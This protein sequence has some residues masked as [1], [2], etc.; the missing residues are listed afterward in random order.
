MGRTGPKRPSHL[1]TAVAGGVAGV[2]ITL[3]IVL[4]GKWT[5]PTG[6][7]S[8][9]N[10]TPNFTQ[11]YASDGAAEPRDVAWASVDRT[12][13]GLDRT[14]DTQVKRDPPPE[15]DLHLKSIIPVNDRVAPARTQPKGER[16]F[17]V[18]D[19]GGHSAT[20]RA[21][22]FLP[23]GEQALTVSLDKTVRIWDWQ[24][25]ETLR[26]L[27]LPVGPGAEGALW[28]GAVSPDGKLLAVGGT[29]YGMG[30]FGVMIYLLSL[31][32][33]EVNKVLRGHTNLITGLAFSHDGR[34]LASTSHDLTVLLYDVASGETVKVFK[35]HTGFP[36]TLAFSA[37][38]K[39]LATASQVDGTVRVWSVETSA[40]MAELHDFPDK[41]ISLAFSPVSDTLA[42]GCQGG[43]LQLWSAGGQRFKEYRIRDREQTQPVAM[44]FTPDGKEIVYGGV[45]WG[46][47]AGIFN[48][49]MGRERIIFREHSNTVMDVRLSPD[50]RRVISTG[51]DNHE[52]FIW[53]VSDGA[54]VQRLA[55]AGKTVWGVGWR[56]DGKA[57]GW[58]NINNDTH[59]ALTPLKHSFVFEDL[60]FGPPPA[61]FGRIATNFG[62]YSLKLLD[63]FTVGISKDGQEVQKFVPGGGERVYSFSIIAGNRAVIGG[64]DRLFLIDLAS[65]QVIRVFTGHTGIVMGVSP[66][67]D[68]R[69]FLT[70]GGDQTICLWDPDREEPLLSLFVAGRDWIAWTPEGYYAASPYGERLMGWLINNGPDRLATFHPAVRFH[71]S[72]YQPAVIKL[73]FQEK[74]LD[75]ALAL[76]GQQL[77]QPLA[78]LS[79]GAVLPPEVAVV[80]PEMSGLTFKQATIEVKARAKSSGD[81]P[82]MAMRLLVDG[83]PYRGE[84]GLRKFAAT[85][86]GEVEAAW[87]VALPPGK[88]QF[89]VIAESKVSKALSPVVEVSREGPLTKERPK[90]YVLAAGISAYPDGAALKFAHLDAMAIEKTLKEKT[91]GLF[92]AVE[93]R[94]LTDVRATRKNILHG[95]SWLEEVTTSNDVAI[96][97]LSG[98]GIRDVGGEF[99][100]IPVDVDG[101]NC[102][103][104]CISGDLL[105][106]SLANVSGRVVVML[107]ACHSGASA[108]TAL[109]NAASQ[110]A[111]A[112]GLMRDL[113]SE[114]YGV[115]TMCSSLGQEYS[116]ENPDAGHGLFTLSLMEA[117]AGRAD[118]NRDGYVHIHEMDRYALERV[119]QLSHGLQNPVT[120]RPP[121]VRSF[122]LA[123]V[124]AP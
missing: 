62:G 83:R 117:L 28:A 89:A 82:V 6:D 122:A 59:R 105:K 100:F 86:L 39:L 120:G 15:P 123:K 66:S 81:Y 71:D 3:A 103:A 47:R 48:L 101:N 60:D 80:S 42:T 21:C 99:Y 45:E 56:L 36:R 54:V 91:K 104:S 5:G 57:I 41:V 74:N 76:A 110:K 32:T 111:A 8:P 124:L 23:D 113:V 119:R 64:S 26:V 85:K 93:T 121:N 25:G 35:G 40:T 75:K 73:I 38:D 17:L 55:A 50:G 18:T 69:Y 24:T 94:L 52:T 37:D 34:W 92:S 84:K 4:A 98:H 29:P 27:H 44:V 112:D 58:G 96:V 87:K 9:S 11:A 88:H 12:P 61:E 63:F 33:G 2:T 115:I 107:D 49:D 72:L 20:V 67:P 19:A 70:G 106:K 78:K 51:G 68:G 65:N 118:F 77:S 10:S 16:P 31:E 13:D 90:L 1:W 14:P 7:A 102:T 108:I 79:L 109:K 116:M 95:L 30:K 97:F 46:G 43:T 22:M 53:N 114:D